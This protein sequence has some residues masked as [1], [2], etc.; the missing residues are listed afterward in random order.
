MPDI[1][2]TVKTDGKS[3]LETLQR[4]GREVDKLEKDIEKLGLEGVAALNRTAR[5][6]EELNRAWHASAVGA[7]ALRREIDLR[8]D[9]EIAAARAA[10]NTARAYKKQRDAAGSL[11]KGTPSQSMGGL[12]LPGLLGRLTPGGIAAA[13]GALL[14]GLVLKGGKS[15]LDKAGALSAA[16]RR[17]AASGA[18][19]SAISRAGDLAMASGIGG[20]EMLG[21]LAS[22][23]KSGLDSAAAVNALEAAVVARGGDWERTGELVQ[24]LIESTAKGWV[25]E[26]GIGQLEK[27]GVAVRE[28][29]QKLLKMDDKQ[30]TQALSNRQITVQ[31]FVKAMSAATAKGTKARD[32]YE[33][34]MNTY[35]GQM[36]RLGQR[37]DEIGETLGKTM[38]PAIER[39]AGAF[40]KFIQRNNNIVQRIAQS[41]EAVIGVLT[42]KITLRGDGWSGVM[43]RLDD[44]ER[45]RYEREAREETERLARQREEQAARQKA[46]STYFAPAPA[47]M[48]GSSEAEQVKAS[49]ETYRGLRAQLDEHER[50]L[51]ANKLTL[52]QRRDDIARRAGVAYTE[53]ASSAGISRRMAELLPDRETVERLNAL[54]ALAAE[55]VKSGIDTNS[56][57]EVAQRLAPVGGEDAATADNKQRMRELFRASGLYTEEAA[58]D[59]TLSKVRDR[60]QQATELAPDTQQ[61]YDELAKLREELEALEAQEAT[62]AAIRAEEEQRRELVDA[63]LAG[64]KEAL[65]ILEARQRVESLTQQYKDKGFEADEARQRAVNTVGEEAAQKWMETQKKAYD[66]QKQEAERQQAARRPELGWIQ[67]GASALGGGNSRVRDVETYL[68]TS[69]RKTEDYTQKTANYAEQIL[70]YLQTSYNPGMTLG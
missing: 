70:N 62:L 8:R 18:T 30:L 69:M 47:G 45:Q 22:L 56:I 55:L 24:A 13:G 48:G 46:L 26:E 34:Q 51:A 43:R 20:P 9:A 64:D 61:R 57:R 42:G 25:T 6:N 23:T 3:L 21:A 33:A 37:W 35:Q 52:Q 28:Q 2:F 38:L 68:S 44:K 14:G 31:Q 66:L 7:R 54:N 12:P 58:K 39:A 15:A 19:P 60:Y 40:L 67:S 4:G 27:A 53:D 32:A 49:M 50:Q 63:R 16:E 11:P 1:K 17:A 10:E 36:A 65:A 59:G 41:V 5:A 29:L